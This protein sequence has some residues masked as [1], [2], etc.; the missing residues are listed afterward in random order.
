[1]KIRSILTALLL[2]LAPLP[3]LASGISMSLTLPNGIATTWH[4]P[5]VYT[6]DLINNVVTISVCHYVTQAA[7]A[8]PAAFVS[9]ESVV[10]PLSAVGAAPTVPLID[11]W[12]VGT[13]L[14]LLPDVDS[15]GNP[16]LDA[17]GHQTSSMKPV[18]NSDLTGGT[19]N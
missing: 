3:A 18:P 12:L 4:Q 19:V 6:V 2:A 10:A 16:I 5:T 8:V 13:T 7:A 17:T 9:C 11:T 14:Q 15:N 1:M